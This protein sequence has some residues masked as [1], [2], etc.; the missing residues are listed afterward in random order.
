MFSIFKRETN[1]VPRRMRSRSLTEEHEVSN[2]DYKGK[3]SSEG[4][5]GDV[6]V[7][8]SRLGTMSVSIEMY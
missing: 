3:V 4:T 8:W 5:R 2:R 1:L 6:V 7:V